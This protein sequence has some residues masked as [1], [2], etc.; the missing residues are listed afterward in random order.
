MGAS[1]GFA[2]LHPL[3]GASVGFAEL[4]PLMRA[5]VGFA[6]LLPLMRASVPRCLNRFSSPELAPGF[7]HLIVLIIKEIPEGLLIF[8]FFLKIKLHIYKLLFYYG[9]QLINRCKPLFNK[10][11]GN[12][13]FCRSLK[14]TEYS[15]NLF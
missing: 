14:I 11:I 2:A 10:M 1:V 15:S 13:C 5:S 9:I 3:M 8:I 7:F 4:L 6:E 12:T